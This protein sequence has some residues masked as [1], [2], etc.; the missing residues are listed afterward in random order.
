M[1][2]ELENLLN[3]DKNAEIINKIKQNPTL[4]DEF[5]RALRESIRRYYDYVK[6]GDSISLNT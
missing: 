3:D 4:K 1:I 6:I 5:N 2:R